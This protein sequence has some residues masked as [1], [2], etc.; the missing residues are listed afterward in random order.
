MGYSVTLMAWEALG[1][2]SSADRSADFAEVTSWLVCL[3]TIV[4]AVSVEDATVKVLS[5]LRGAASPQP[6]FDE[7][8]IYDALAWLFDGGKERDMRVANSSRF[9]QSHVL[10]ADV[11]LPSD[12]QSLRQAFAYVL[13][14]KLSFTEC[15]NAGEG[16]VLMFHEVAYLSA[17][18]DQRKFRSSLSTALATV[19]TS[20]GALAGLL[21][22]SVAEIVA[23]GQFKDHGTFTLQAPL[24]AE[25]CLKTLGRCGIEFSAVDCGASTL[26]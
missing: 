25:C 1:L 26:N 17:A 13:S 15:K 8:G 10:Y 3:R 22:A 2:F 18:G 6:C 9:T 19:P 7:Q 23:T 5:V 14:Q 20:A 4:G 16:L 24:L 21:A 11:V 12:C